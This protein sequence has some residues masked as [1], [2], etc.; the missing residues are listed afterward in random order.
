MSGLARSLR[1]GERVWAV[2]DECIAGNEMVV[3]FTGDLVRVKNSTG[4]FFRPGERVQLQVALLYPLSFRLVEPRFSRKLSLD[5][6]I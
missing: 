6:T 4:R 5:Q 2:V 3:N 1:L